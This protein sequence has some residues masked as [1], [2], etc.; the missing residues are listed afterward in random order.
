VSRR[1][2][3]KK[4]KGKRREKEFGKWAGGTYLRTKK[5]RRRRKEFCSGLAEGTPIQSL[6]CEKEEEYSGRI[7][8]FHILNNKA[9]G[10][11]LCPTLS[12]LNPD[13]NPKA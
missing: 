8:Y 7:T 1:N 3:L 2:V 10:R 11:R 4:K 13:L 12:T 5:K 9:V 6:G